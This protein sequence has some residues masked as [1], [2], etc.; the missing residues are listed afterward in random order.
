V[1]YDGQNEIKA[2]VIFAPL[3]AVSEPQNAGERAINQF[4]AELALG[5][6]KVVGD[7]DGLSGS[8]VFSLKKVGG[9]WFYKVI[10]VQSSVYLPS[11]TLAICPFSTFAFEV[12]G[13]LG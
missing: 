11:R 12:E 1:E 10:G 6:E 8:P 3:L 2:R 7:P 9:Q 5:A 4:Y 13:L